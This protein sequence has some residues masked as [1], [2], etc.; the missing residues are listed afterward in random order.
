VEHGLGNPF[1][2]DHLQRAHLQKLSDEAFANLGI[3]SVEKKV[4]VFLE[5]ENTPRFC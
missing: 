4:S 3:D 1:A 2:V 5:K